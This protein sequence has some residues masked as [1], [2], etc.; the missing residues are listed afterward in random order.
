[1]THQVPKETME[2]ERAKEES[3]ENV[4]AVHAGVMENNI[5]S[6]NVPRERA[7]GPSLQL[8]IAGA[9]GT[10]QA[11]RPNNGDNGFPKANI[12]KVNLKVKG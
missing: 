9:Q 12:P 5:S 2:K 3:V 10:S 8:G 11:H 6:E 4:L 7:K 1:M